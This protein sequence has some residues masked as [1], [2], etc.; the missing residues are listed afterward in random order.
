MNTLK[1]KSVLRKMR[2]PV[3]TSVLCALTTL[4]GADTSKWSTEGTA[5][6]LRVNDGEPVTFFAVGMCYS[7]APIGDAGDGALPFQDFFYYH[8]GDPNNQRGYTPIWERDIGTTAKPGHLRKMGVNTIRVY[9]MFK[10]GYTD[11]NGRP[12]FA[13]WKNLDWSTNPPPVQNWWTHH[14]HEKFLDMCWN[15]GENPIYVL[16]GVPFAEAPFG[17]PENPQDAKQKEDSYQFFLKTAEWL[18][19]RYGNH[20]AVMGFILGNEHDSEAATKGGIPGTPPENYYGPEYL[21]D[22]KQQPLQKISDTEWQGMPVGNYWRT[23]YHDKLNNMVEAI[24]KHAPD[25]LVTSAFH[26]KQYFASHWLAVPDDNNQRIKLIEQDV[27]EYSKLDFFSFNIY[28]SPEN[29]MQALQQ[30]YLDYAK[31]HGKEKYIRPIM[32]TEMGIPASG[33]NGGQVVELENDAQKQ[34]E[35]LVSMWEAGIK[36]RVGSEGPYPHLSG[37]YTFSYSDEWFKYKDG[38]ITKHDGGGSGASQFPGGHWDEEWFG[39]FRVAANPG[40]KPGPM[41]TGNPHFAGQNDSTPLE[42]RPVVSDFDAGNLNGGPD[43]LTPRAAVANLKALYAKYGVGYAS[44]TQSVREG[45]TSTVKDAVKD[46]G[47][48]LNNKGRTP[49][50]GDFLDN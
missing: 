14:G 21:L 44:E 6:K 50:V 11:N 49:G 7:P 29:A 45:A 34:S 10:H 43:V 22:Y 33:R 20:P 40:R 18:A 12:L 8:V 25:K 4:V 38:N 32:F 3:L 1:Y 24:K 26:D 2:F 41:V 17:F 5:I 48:K 23:T 28:Q 9:S 47:G 31:K 37:I 19:E 27:L 39:V 15:N 46:T 30:R 35:R 42:E 36:N 16:I 13:E